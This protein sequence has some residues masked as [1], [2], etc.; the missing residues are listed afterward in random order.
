MRHDKKWRA[1]EESEEDG[2]RKEPEC[3]SASLM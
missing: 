1:R 2:G 3:Q